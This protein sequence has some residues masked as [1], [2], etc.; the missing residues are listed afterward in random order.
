LKK[1][2]FVWRTIMLSRNMLSQPYS[3]LV[4]FFVISLFRAPLFFYFSF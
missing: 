1:L 3:Q 2:N 4:S